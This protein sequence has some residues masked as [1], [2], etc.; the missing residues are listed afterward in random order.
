MLKRRLE[1][2]QQMAEISAHVKLARAAVER[3]VREGRTIAVPEDTPDELLNTRAGAFVCLKKGG[4]LRGCIGT[5]EPTQESLAQ[6]IMCNAISAATR[7]PRFNLVEPSELDDLDYSVDVLTPAEEI[8]SHEDLDPAR[9]G[10]IVE[11]HMRRGLLLPDLEGVDTVEEQLDIARRKAGIERHEPIKLYRF[12]V[13][14][15]H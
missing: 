13:V 5:T 1:V 8:A 7:D 14:R 4:A 15:H 9:Y 11:S 10:V 6:E 2:R 3:Y 12:E